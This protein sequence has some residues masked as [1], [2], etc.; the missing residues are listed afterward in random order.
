MKRHMK[1]PYITEECDVYFEIVNGNLKLKQ[2]GCG[3]FDKAQFLE[4]AQHTDCS[5]LVEKP[6]WKE[7]L[8]R[9]YCKMF[10]KMP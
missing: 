8:I 2:N 5:M 1:C 6:N 10:R 3:Y 9:Q 7:N 4:M